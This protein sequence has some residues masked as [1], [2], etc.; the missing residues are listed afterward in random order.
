MTDLERLAAR[1]EAADGEVVKDLMR[2]LSDLQMW[3]ILMSRKDSG[4]QAAYDL[5]Q[6]TRAFIAQHHLGRARAM[7]ANDGQ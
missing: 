5:V 7:E 3:C 6:E 4:G 1:C 2:R